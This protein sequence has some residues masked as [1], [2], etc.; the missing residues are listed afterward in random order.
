MPAVPAPLSARATSAQQERGGHWE[1]CRWPTARREAG[2]AHRA[3]C[4][5][6]AGEKRVER[7]L[8][9]PVVPA[10]YGAIALPHRMGPMSQ[11]PTAGPEP[12][13][14]TE[15]PWSHTGD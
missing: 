14:H 15:E 7:H 13:G 10:E 12:Q 4:Q 6:Q 8:I 11:G 5:P 9:L 1:P 2:A 3:H